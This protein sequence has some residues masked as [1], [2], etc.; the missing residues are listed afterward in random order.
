MA[1]IRHVPLWK[2]FRLYSL[3]RR[4]M[5]S[6]A[7]YTGCIMRIGPHRLQR[8]KASTTIPPS[9]TVWTRASVPFRILDVEFRPSEVLFTLEPE[10]YRIYLAD[11]NDTAD[12]EAK[13]SKDGRFGP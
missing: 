1:L 3:P 12:S 9:T 13:V 11:F 6:W 8:K 2:A 5:L 4:Q 10:T 7:S